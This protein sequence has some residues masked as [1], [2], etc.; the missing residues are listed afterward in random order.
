MISRMI[1]YLTL[2][3]SRNKVERLLVELVQGGIPG[4]ALAHG[5]VFK[6]E[7]SFHAGLARAPG[8]LGIAKIQ[9]AI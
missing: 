2:V 6:P 8:R 3:Q 1:G 5:I 4:P 9:F 7:K